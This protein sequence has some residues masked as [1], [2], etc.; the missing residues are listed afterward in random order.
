L[1]KKRRV[2]AKGVFRGEFHVLTERPGIGDHL[3]RDTQH[4]KWRQTSEGEVNGRQG[5]QRWETIE[6]HGH[7]AART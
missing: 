3:P 7:K 2:G 4:L 5:R 1:V 6:A